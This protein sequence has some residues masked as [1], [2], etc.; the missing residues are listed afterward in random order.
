MTPE[1]F[2]AFMGKVRDMRNAQKAYFRGRGRPGSDTLLEL[3]K[4]LER[5]VDS[6]ISEIERKRADSGQTKLF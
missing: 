1:E 6:L 4:S 5:E 2:T 3:A